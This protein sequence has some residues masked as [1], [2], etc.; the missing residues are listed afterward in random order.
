M[1]AQIPTFENMPLPITALSHQARQTTAT[2]SIL[3]PMLSP[4]RMPTPSYTASPLL[5]ATQ[6][7]MSSQIQTEL[8]IQKFK[9]EYTSLLQNF[10]QNEQPDSIPVSHE[11]PK[12]TNENTTEST[13]SD[14]DETSSCSMTDSQNETKST[15]LRSLRSKR[16]TFPSVLYEMLQKQNDSYT[17]M[18]SWLPDGKG[19]MI[20]SKTEFEKVLL[21]KYFRGIK[22]RSF[23]RQ[24]NIY[25]FTRLD[26]HKLLSYRHNLFVRNQHHLLRDIKRVPIKKLSSAQD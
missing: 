21:Q 14:S 19:F 26:T 9:T 22:F 1:E 5:P 20:H 17:N 6:L 3:N 18:I 25:G 4:F 2:N 8:A 10:T 24:L 13:E 11:K 7:N 12:D 15:K 16:K 23:Q